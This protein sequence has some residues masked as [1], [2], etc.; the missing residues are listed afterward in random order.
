MSTCTRCGAIFSCAMA[1]NTT[2]ACWC[3]ALPAAVPV[4][5]EAAGC[6]CRICLETHIADLSRTKLASPPQQQS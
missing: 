3:T 2:G 5:Q 4:P 6:W 1:D